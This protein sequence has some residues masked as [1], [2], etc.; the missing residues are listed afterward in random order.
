MNKAAI[1]G[2]TDRNCNYMALSSPLTN[3]LFNLIL[4]TFTYIVDNVDAC[5]AWI[6]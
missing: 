5:E 3:K 6:S 1:Y 2:N 4:I